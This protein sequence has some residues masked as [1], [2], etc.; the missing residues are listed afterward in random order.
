M[1]FAVEAP[2]DDD[3]GAG[4]DEEGV[5]VG[6]GAV[7]DFVH[8][9]AG[10]VAVVAAG[11]VGADGGE[12]TDEH[13][14]GL[15][16]EVGG[17][18]IEGFLRGHSFAAEAVRSEGIEPARIGLENGTDAFGERGVGVVFQSDLAGERDQFIGD[19]GERGVVIDE[20]ARSPRTPRE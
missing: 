3:E 4:A 2:V 18:E 20:D 1:D 15:E 10:G 13:R 8:A 5:D 14:E 16:P 7:E 9:A 12:H 17:D 19:D 11:G 6:E